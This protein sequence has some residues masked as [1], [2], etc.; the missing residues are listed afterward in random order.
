MKI[1]FLIPT[2]RYG[3]AEK[4]ATEL[5]FNLP[6]DWDVVFIVFENKVEYPY[7]GR[8]ISLDLPSEKNILKDTKNFFFRILRLRKIA[9]KENFDAIISFDDY[10]NLLNIIAGKKPIISV[11]KSIVMADKGKSAIKRMMS[12]LL[13]S[14]FYPI[15]SKIVAVSEGV[16]EELMNYAKID[17]GKITVINNPYNIESIQKKANEK[18][19]VKIQGD[20]VINIGRMEPQK[21]QWHLIRAFSK[22]RTKYPDLKLVILGRGS[23][24]DYLRKLIQDM[25]LSNSVLLIETRMDNI[26]PIL[27]GAKLFVL[28][29]IFEGFSNVIVESLAIGIPVISTDCKTGPRGILKV[30]GAT[31]NRVESYGILVPVPDGI[32]KT[33]DQPLTK[34]EV[35]LADAIIALLEDEKTRKEFSEKGKARANDFDVRNVIPKYIALMT[36]KEK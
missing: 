21:G 25:K 6:K 17:P 36:S 34:E 4:I 35:E 15:A 32:L 2:L 26:Y 31:E 10:A 29:S 9:K 23:I 18:P 3:G 22:V 7:R 5:S 20:Y 1:A 16:N 27:R 33:A 13:R 19:E 14:L 24:S 28:P 8:L 12:K 11:H 30:E